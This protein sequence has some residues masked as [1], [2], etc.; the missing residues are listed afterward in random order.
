MIAFRKIRSSFRRAILV[1][2]LAIVGPTLVFLYLGLQ[3]VQ[4]QHQ[5]ITSLTVSNLRLSGERLAAEL[6]RRVWQLAK[7]SLQN[8]ELLQLQLPPG[9]AN[10]PE[11]TRQLRML[12]ERVKDRHSVVRH[13]FILRGS[14][15]IFPLVRTP[16]LR[17]L[18]DYIT[19]EDQEAGKR[20]AALFT[21]GENRE[22]RQQRPKQALSFY[23]QSYEMP[24]SE[25]SKALALARVARCLRKVN[26]LKAAERAYR[27]LG[28]QFGDLYD[29]FHRPYALV[30]AFE[31]DDLAR[32][33]GES[34]SQSLIDINRDL[35]QG[36]WELSTDQI[37]YSL[38]AIEERLEEPMPQMGE[39]EYLNHL[40]MASVLQEGFRH[41]GPLR[42]GEVYAYAF[43]QGETSYQT[44]YSPLPAGR[45]TD[46]LV[47]FAVDLNWVESQLLPQ[48]RRELEVDDGFA[49]ALKVAKIPAP[50]PND[51]AATVSFTT[52][53]PFW[54][55]SMA[56]ASIEAW[57]ATTRRGILVFAGST[58]L[59]FCVLILGVFLLMR[60]V[61]RELKL[62]RLRADFISSVSHE[63]KTPL[64]LIRLYGETLLHGK[65]SREKERKSYYQ[66]IT[67]ESERLSHLI[68][69]VLDFS[70]I[71]R[72]QKQYNLQEGDVAPVVARTVEVYGEYLMRQGFSVK[73]DLAAHLPPVQFDPD[74]ISEAILNLMDNA[75]KFAGE[76]KFVGVRLRSD[77]NQVVFEVEDHGIG[78]PPGEHEKIFRQFYRAP[79]RTGKGGY[80]LGLFLVKHIMDAHG[81]KIELESEPG[82]GSLFRLIFPVREPGEGVGGSPEH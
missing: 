65:R 8:D 23:R 31:L 30:A 82:C 47:G 63:L 61:S 38:A 40:E 27:K 57:K 80:G 2:L 76:S 59:I 11:E 44:F 71:D 52:L 6:E 25:G 10:Y 29:G 19:R 26:Q 18:D 33:Q 72:G 70:R 50:H 43:S 13:Y 62:G 28:E 12:L 14:T 64:T 1:Y 48:W 77:D 81:G 54:Q 51:L 68:E 4:R 56:P 22:L 5:A 17:Q 78:I 42:V 53:F 55:L 39:S 3:S 15:V 66:I 49:V 69:K 21:E 79:G 7:T 24:V 35:V 45:G 9:D 36:R 46:T 74:A 73:T 67:R 41:Y 34:S 16:S 20:F 58:I 32:M 37:E 60:D 75:A